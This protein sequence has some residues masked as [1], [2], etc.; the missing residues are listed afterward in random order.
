MGG[1]GGLCLITEEIQYEKGIYP[2]RITPVCRSGPGCT[3]L[4]T[5]LVNV[6]ISNVYI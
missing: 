1:G 2:S 4:T 6:K 3:K 5:S